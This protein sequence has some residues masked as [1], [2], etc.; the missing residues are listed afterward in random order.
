M[1]E[2]KAQIIELESL[3]F[4]YSDRDRLRMKQ[5]E[6][7]LYKLNMSLLDMMCNDFEKAA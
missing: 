6:K 3:I 7:E 5:L 4:I 1:E 2:L